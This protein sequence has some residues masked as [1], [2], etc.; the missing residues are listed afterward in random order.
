MVSKTYS[1]NLYGHVIT[2]LVEINKDTEPLNKY[3]RGIYR[4][5]KQKFKKMQPKTTNRTTKEGLC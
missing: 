5:R 4:P 2:K 1:R 3:L